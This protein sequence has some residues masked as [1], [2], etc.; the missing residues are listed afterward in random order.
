MIVIR[1]T[2]KAKPGMASKLAQQLYDATAGGPERVRVL[3]DLVAQFNTVVIETEI[4]DLA[5][6]EKRMEEYRVDAEIRKKMAGYTDLY[7]EG[8]RE[9]YRVVGGTGGRVK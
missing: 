4:A 7:I 3:T 9:I 6:F 8:R 1:E 2:F 5:T